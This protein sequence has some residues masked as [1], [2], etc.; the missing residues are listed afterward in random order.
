VVGGIPTPLKNDGRI[1]SWDDDIPNR[2]KVIKFM[3]QTTS[4]VSLGFSFMFMANNMAPMI[5]GVVK[6]CEDSPSFFWLLGAYRLIIP[7]HKARRFW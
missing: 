7:I 4:Q 2:W 1:V 3:F 6:I 5:D